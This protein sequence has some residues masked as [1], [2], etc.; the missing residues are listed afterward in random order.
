[1]KSRKPEETTELVIKALKKTNQRAIFLAGW[2]GL[3]KEDLP[4]SIFMIDSVPHTWFFPRVAAVVH[5]GSA[6][7]T[8]EG[9][10]AGVPSNAVPFFC[11]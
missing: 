3:L 2:G 10:R 11:F 9:P 7:T 8:G 5:Q 6:G 4:D 1:M